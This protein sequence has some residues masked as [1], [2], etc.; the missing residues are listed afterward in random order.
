MNGFFSPEAMAALQEAYQMQLTPD[1][2]DIDQT[3]GLP[4]NQVS[5]TAPWHGTVELWKY[6]N[7]V[8]PTKQG[9]IHYIPRDSED[10][11]DEDDLDEL[12]DSLDDDG[13]DE[14]DSESIDDIYED[15]SDED[16]EP[17][18]E[19]EVD[20]LIEELLASDEDD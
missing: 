12:I 8:T 6:P 13:D 7:G 10:E 9:E 14:D 5:N 20:A 1:E 19:D 11:G 15:S 3:T 18:T 16:D 17:M 4:T 2:M